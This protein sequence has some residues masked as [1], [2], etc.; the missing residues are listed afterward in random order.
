MNLSMGK[1]CAGKRI[2]FLGESIH[3]V[4]KFNMLRG[5]VAD[6]FFKK[7]SILVFEADSAGMYLS[8][9]LKEKGLIRL[10]NFP[11]I[12]RTKEVLDIIIWSIVNEVP[13]FGIDCIP[14]RDL[15][16]FPIKW[17][18]CRNQEVL[19]YKEMK[20][21]KHYFFWRS[22]KMAENLLLIAEKYPEHKL[23]V[24]L[25]N[26]H[27]KRKGSY[28]IGNLR[29]RSVREF[30][31]T[32]LPG[33]SVSVAQFAKGGN[34]LH[35][36]LTPFSFEIDDTSAIENYHQTM[37]PAL[38]VREQIPRNRVAWHHVFERETL[39]VK[40]QYEGCIIYQKVNS[41]KLLK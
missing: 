4:D 28:E 24:M 31:E 15:S 23:L 20:K 29:L 41:P 30:I 25:H 10:S 9:S 18:E 1:L 3:G 34:A 27:I 32:D 35:N 5:Q 16:D 7:K 12:M 11:L 6:E 2:V 22:R 39:P 13:S 8:H 33:Q 21:T 38:L 37:D 26:L 19:L 40:E 14:R 36:D 17:Q